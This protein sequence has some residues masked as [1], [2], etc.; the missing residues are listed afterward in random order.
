MVDD[1]RIGRRGF[2]VRAGVLAAMVATGPAWLRSS[3]ALAGSH[4]ELISELRPVL[5]E[6]ARDTVGGLIAFAVP[7]P[8]GY[9]ETQGV[10]TGEPGGVDAGG[11]DFMLGALDFFFP[12]PSEVA[13]PLVQSLATGI[14]EEAADLPP[15]LFDVPLDVARQLDDALSALFET[16]EAMP[17]SVVI[18]LLLNWTATRADPASIVGP[19]PAPFANLAFDDK[20]EVFRILE[21]DTAEVVAA[22]DENLS[23]PMRASLSGM[24]RFVPGALIEFAAFGSFTEFDVLDPD[25]RTLTGVP[26]GWQLS[27]YLEETGF[28]PVEGWDDLQ[29]WWEGRRQVSG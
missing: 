20:V 18:A 17:L 1:R 7:G 28:R 12:L 16:D 23:E 8:D 13:R 21:E 10:T 24:L 22:L 9:S 5:Q 29:G 15:E 11:I 4:D 27:R 6:L 19:H 26:V 25:T 2:L 3:R 14:E